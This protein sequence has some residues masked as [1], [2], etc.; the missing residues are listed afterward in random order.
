MN[1]HRNPRRRPATLVVGGTLVLAAS[2]AGCSV[3]GV[4]SGGGAGDGTGTVKALFMKQAGYTE[5]DYA[6]IIEDFEAE[7]PDI[8]V[9]P[10][11]VSYEALHDK[12]VTSAPSGSYDVVLIDVIWPAEFASK[13]IIADLTDRFPDEWSDEMLPGVLPTAEYQ[14]RYYGVPN[15][16]ATKLFYFNKEMVAAVGAS[17]ADLATWDGVLE[18]AR[19]IK[20]QGISEYP[21]AWSWAQAE[22]L[23]C[24]YAQLLGAFGGEFT[25]DEGRLII[26]DGAGVAALEWMIRILEEGLSNPAS[27]TFLEDDVSKAMAQG[28][29]AFGL[30]WDSTLRDLQDPSISSIEAGVLPTPAGPD[31][32]RP[33]VNG[34][35]AYSIGA[36]S[37]NQD[38]AWEF[39]SFITRQEVQ[40]QY[41]ESSLPNWTS[42]Y[43]DEELVATNPEIFEV[44]EE[45][46]DASIL[47]PAVPNYSSV[48]Q[49]IQVELQNALLG[50]KSAQE[51]LDDAVAA[52]NAKL[53]G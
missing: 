35:M 11:F 52:A 36:N 24:D 12:I 40:D 21:I 27:T 4:S 50:D 26:N 51:A 7:H 22:A 44:A 28:Q 9:E 33:G 32:A 19:R 43:T 38:A 39:I 29:T 48:S 45:A 30:N 25:D 2:L 31:G 23:I 47:R 34:A 17:E 10:T 37:K 14:G 18:V 5:E 8:D 20:A 42:S 3:T 6:A 41:V 53:E 16:P 1:I 15:G 49:I 46:Y 13:G